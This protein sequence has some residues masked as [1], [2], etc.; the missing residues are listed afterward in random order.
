MCLAIPGRI[1]KILNTED[2]LRQAII[3]FGGIHKEICIAWVDAS[4]GDYVLSHSGM[5]I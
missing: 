5:A 4:V 1:V 3:N 2:S